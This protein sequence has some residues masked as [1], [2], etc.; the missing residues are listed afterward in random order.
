[1]KIIPLSRKSRLTPRSKSA[2]FSLVE[3]LL[4]VAVIGIISGLAMTYMGGTSEH[5]RSL[6]ARQQQVQL[7]TALDA[8]ITATASGTAGLAA[9]KAAY[10]TDA[11]AMLTALAPYLREPGIFTASGGGLSSSAL[12]GIG[13]TLQFSSWSEGSYPK[14]LMQ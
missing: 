2:A 10:S 9:A 1:V 14:V 13:K 11:G 6:V 5:S 8:W 4:V 7:Q 12:A 3:I